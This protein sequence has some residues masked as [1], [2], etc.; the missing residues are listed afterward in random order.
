MQEKS[1]DIPLHDIK[2]IVDV[3]EYSFYYFLGLIGIVIVVIIGISYLIYLWYKKKTAFNLRVYH[4]QLLNELDLQ[5]TKKS[6]YAIS[7][8]GET[9]KD[10]SPRHSEMYKNLS[11]RLQEY[12]YQK[13][14]EN[15]DDEIL[16]YIELYKGMIDV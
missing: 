12:K 14:V 1:Y 8:Y 13:N 11:T 7:A 9:F 10:D 4:S 16:G 2:P 6:A 5:D 3:Q 15:F